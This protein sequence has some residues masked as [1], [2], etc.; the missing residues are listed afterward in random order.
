MHHRHRR[1]GHG[2]DPGQRVGGGRSGVRRQGGRERVRSTHG[3]DGSRWCV[4]LRRPPRPSEACDP[5]T[6]SVHLVVRFVRARPIRPVADGADDHAGRASG[7]STTQTLLVLIGLA[8]LALLLVPGLLSRRLE[9][10]STGDGRGG[11]TPATR[12]SRRSGRG[13]AVPAAPCSARASAP[14]VGLV[15]FV[16]VPG[17]QPGA[18]A[19]AEP[20]G[21]QPGDRDVPAGHVSAVTVSGTRC[22]L[23][24]PG[25]RQPDAEPGGPGRL[26]VVDGGDPDHVRHRLPVQLPADLRVLGR[27]AEHR[28]STTDDPGPLPTQCQFGAETDLQLGLPGVKEPGFEYSRVLSQQSW[29]NYDTTS[30][31]TGSVDRLPRRALPGRRRH[32]RRPAGRLQ[33]RP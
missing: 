22:L 10:R 21:R 8:L 32:P 18:G 2:L 1:C 23:G 4:R 6:G 17:L 31:W 15:V 24:T 11:S 5:T 16:T 19:A 3:V 26:G 14:L 33:L 13:P 30:G 27:P 25:H 20:A 12:R 28:P 9:R 29:S 7:W